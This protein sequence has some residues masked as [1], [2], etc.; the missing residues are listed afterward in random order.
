[1]NIRSH[2]ELFP[3]WTVV[4]S[5]TPQQVKM[6]ASPLFWVFHVASDFQ[7]GG[8]KLPTT[9]FVC[10]VEK[11]LYCRDWLCAEIDFCGCLF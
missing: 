8:E 9:V 5:L 11:K 2:T 1:M 4:I 3:P 7:Q 10:G 6:F